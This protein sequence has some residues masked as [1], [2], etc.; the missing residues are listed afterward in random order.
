MAERHADWLRQAKRDL[1]HARRSAESGDYEWSCF[2]AQ[3]SAEKAVK[4]VYQWLGAVA[5]GHS[6]TMLITNLP[7]A[8]RP[9]GELVDR[10]KALDKHYIT[11][12]YPNGFE[13]GAPLDYYT[14]GEAERSV[15]DANHII[16]FCED[17]LARSGGGDKRA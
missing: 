1:A 10:A 16:R 14:L 15:E 11:T 4:A 6:V 5:W 9:G 8:Y 2:A 13:Q 12:R 7:E 17:F 3:Q